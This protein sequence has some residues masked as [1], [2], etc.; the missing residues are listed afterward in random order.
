MPERSGLFYGKVEHGRIVLQ[1]RDGFASLIARLNGCEID[2]ELRKHRR[3]RTTL[4]NAYYWSVVVGMVSE[5]TGYLPCEAHDAL[6]QMFLTDNT[7][8][9]LPRVRSTTDLTTIEF[10]EYVAHCVQ[11]AAEKLELV[12]PDPE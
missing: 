8:Q 9:L 6:R 5:S 1:N 2:I 11:F 12:I 10:S 3:N 4:Q 7:D